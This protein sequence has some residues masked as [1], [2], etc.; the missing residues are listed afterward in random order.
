MASNDATDMPDKDLPLRD[1]IRLL[2][3]ILGDTV[4]EQQGDAVFEMVEHI[5]QTSIRFHRNEDMQRG[6]SWKRR[7]TACRQTKPD[8]SSAPSASSRTSP[9][10]PK[11]SIISVA[12]ARMPWPL[13][14]RATAPWPMRWRELRSRPVTRRAAG[15]LRVVRKSPRC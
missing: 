10:S 12:R 9:T 7:S 11:T 4:R 3:R 6:A 1:D 5:R 14:R 8:T 13:R 15:L 2:G